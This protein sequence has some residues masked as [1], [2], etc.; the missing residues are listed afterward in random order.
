MPAVIQDTRPGS[1]YRPPGSPYRGNT[2]PPDN[3]PRS[4]GPS[5]SPYG[6][7]GGYPASSHSP[8]IQGEQGMLPAPEGFSRPPSAAQPYTQF[9][10]MKIQ[11]ME[12]FVDH[13]PRLPSVLVPHDVYHEDW[14]RL[15]TDLASAWVG[16]LPIPE[17]ARVGGRMP[18]RSTVAADLIDLWNASFFIPRGV[19]LVLY[20]GRERRSGRLAGQVDKNLPGFDGSYYDDSVSGSDLSNGSDS[21]YAYGRRNEIAELREARRRR[22]E[23]EEDEK[24]KKKD[25]ARRRMRELEKKYSVYLICLEQ[26]VYR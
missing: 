3:R 17:T 22:K 9:N 1:P 2:Y 25:R 26:P 18:R 10:P 23:M 6:A 24:R 19:E 15:M 7:P 8:V 20:K 14:I 21:D 11:D 13:I 4:R 16:R 12:D 5:P